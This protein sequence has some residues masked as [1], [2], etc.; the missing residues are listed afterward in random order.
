MGKIWFFFFKKK[1]YTKV[2]I[3]IRLDLLFLFL[4][5]KSIIREWK[6]KD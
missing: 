4:E 2:I 3:K 6:L 5:V 1:K